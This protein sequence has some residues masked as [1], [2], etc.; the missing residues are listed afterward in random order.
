MDSEYR[1]QEELYRIK[2]SDYYGVARTEMLPYV[3]ADGK[4]IL[5]VGCGSG[6]FGRALK[7]RRPETVVWGI[8][9]DVAAGQVA[10]QTL[11]RVIPGTFSSVLSE[12][13]TERFDVI[14]LNDVI[15]HIADPY[16]VLRECKDLLTSDGM[17]VASIPN[18][19]FFYEIAKILITQDWKYED[20][21]VLDNTHLRFF[22]KKSIIRMFDECGYEILKIEGIN[23]FAG[24]KFRFFNAVSLGH[25][26][27]WK[28]VQFAVQAR[29]RKIAR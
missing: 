29:V 22:T 1:D 3:P 5:E 25:I 9:P 2:P 11:D 23:A 14:C 17:V 20:C 28:Y 27:D 7:Q 10:A 19:L 12:L 16:Q 21:G 13:A 18:V 26:K 15:E 6:A 8:E 24:R 4:L